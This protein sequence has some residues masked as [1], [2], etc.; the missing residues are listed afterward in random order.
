[1][2]CFR[3]TEDAEFYGYNK[4]RTFQIADPWLGPNFQGPCYS[5][6][7]IHKWPPKGSF[8]PCW[9]WA[10]SRYWC[11][12]QSCGSSS[13]NQGMSAYR[14]AYTWDL[15]GNLDPNDW[16]F[17]TRNFLPRTRRICAAATLPRSQCRST[18]PDIYSKRYSWCRNQHLDTVCRCPPRAAPRS[19]LLFPSYQEPHPTC[20]PS[21]QWQSASIRSRPQLY[22]RRLVASW[23][24][25]QFRCLVKVCLS[26]WSHPHSS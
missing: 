21:M 3:G 19:R 13:R 5:Q 17:R 6:D 18:R 14:S 24:R 11:Q 4:Q 20:Q 10:A 9:R 25:C 23:N 1:M 8:R 15:I 7:S 22:P 2:N 12:W 26:N 16:W